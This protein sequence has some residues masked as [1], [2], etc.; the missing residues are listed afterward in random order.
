[1]KNLFLKKPAQVVATIGTLIALGITFGLNLTADQIGAIMAALISIG[2]LITESQVA[3]TA[4]L[5]ELAANP[6]A[7]TAPEKP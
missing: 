7:T 2:G 6:P 4:A 3:S 1:M 5:A